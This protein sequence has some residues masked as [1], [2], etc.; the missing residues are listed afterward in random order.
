MSLLLEAKNISKT[1][2]STEN[3]TLFHDINLTCFEGQTLAITGPSGVGKSTLLHILGTLETPSTGQ[4]YIEGKCAE[5]TN[6]SLIRNQKIG[7]V[8]QSYHLLE[9]YTVIENVLLPALIKKQSI[10]KG[11]LAYKRGLEL[12]DLVG[13]YHKKDLPSKFLSGGEKQR[14]AIARAL[15]NDPPLL[16][17]DEPTGNLD[18]KNGESIHELLLY[19]AKK[20]HKGLIV[21]THNSCLS[22]RC[23]K[24]FLLKNGILE[25]VQ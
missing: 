25:C 1:F 11:S 24:K 5:K 22:N 9:D 8:F 12:L 3:I 6:F 23:D 4:I 18:E 10:F 21:V 17:A 7:F 2:F 13:L 20:L 16:L 14:V 15:C 19:S